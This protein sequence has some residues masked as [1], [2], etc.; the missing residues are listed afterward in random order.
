MT[1]RTWMY[2]NL[3]HFNNDKITTI[4]LAGLIVSNDTDT[5]TYECP[6]GCALLRPLDATH[7]QCSE[8]NSVITVPSNTFFIP[9]P[10][11]Y[12]W[13]KATSLETDT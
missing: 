11:D 1:R 4:N 6:C 10:D 3:S 9:G 7:G 8:C 2:T 5:I 13:L 12:E